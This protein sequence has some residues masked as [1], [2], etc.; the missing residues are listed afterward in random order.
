MLTF[1]GV[2]IQRDDNACKLVDFGG[3]VFS[4]FQAK[5][6]SG[7]MCFNG[8][9]VLNKQIKLST[10]LFLADLDFFQYHAHFDYDNYPKYHPHLNPFSYRVESRSKVIHEITSKLSTLE[11]LK[12]FDTSWTIVITWNCRLE[13]LNSI[14]ESL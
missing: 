2:P 6:N 9:F 13:V 8:L 11:S 4:Y 10:E 3:N 14:G 12:N 1:S 7:Y 5:Y